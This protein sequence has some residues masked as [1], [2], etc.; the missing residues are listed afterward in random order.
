MA[1]SEFWETYN[2][3][4]LVKDLTCYKNPSKPA[5]MN[6]IFT[7]FPKLFQHTQT[8]ET[9]LPDLHKLTLTVS[10]THFPRLKPSIANYRD[11]KRFANEYF[12]S[13]LLQGINVSGSGITNFKDLCDTLQ[14]VLHKHAL[15]LKKKRYARVDQQN[16]M[17]KGLNQAIMVR[18]KLRNKYLK[19]K[20]EK[21]KQRY[22]KERSRRGGGGKTTPPPV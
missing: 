17:V 12:R 16:F 7:N 11:Y 6:L 14:R 1:I 10:K 15:F 3:Q 18:S 8:I 19:S 4:N 13:K 9:G 5:C 21:D 20:L 2:F 22:S